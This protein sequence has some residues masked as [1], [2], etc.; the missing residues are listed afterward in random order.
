MILKRSV[1]R[2]AVV[3]LGVGL[4]SSL[5]LAQAAAREPSAGARP[6][7]YGTGTTTTDVCPAPRPGHFSCLA[8]VVVADGTGQVLRSTTPLGLGPTDLQRA[9]ELPIHRGE[10][11]TI[12]VVA[13]FDHPDAEA[14]LKRY[15]AHFGLPPCTT[16]NGCFTKIDQRGGTDYPVPDDGWALEI[17]LDLDMVSATCP[18]CRILLVVADDNSFQNLAYAVDQAASRRVAA[19]N[20]SYGIGRDIRDTRLLPDGTPIGDHYKHPGIAVTVAS[21]DSGYGVSY[22]AA[23]RYTVAVGGT[24]LRRADNQ[25]GWSETAWRYAGSGCS[26]NNAK[27]NWQSGI[28]CRHRVVADVAAVADPTTGVAVYHSYNAVPRGWFILGGTSASSP[29]IAAIYGLAGNGSSVRYPASLL[30]RDPDRLRD[31]TRGGNGFC[32]EAYLCIARPGY[33][34]PTGLGTP[35]GIGAFRA[36]SQGD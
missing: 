21:G 1:G 25:R 6:P 7:T 30:Y 35:R 29:I 17:S 32:N 13:A 36:V 18:K 22:P 33:D 5:A 34:G 14:D 20:N 12:A 23:S 4:I 15:R 8:K 24:S 9:Y 2:L 3:I 27:P 11:Q 10:G 16:A 26:S 31:I 19:I 28:P